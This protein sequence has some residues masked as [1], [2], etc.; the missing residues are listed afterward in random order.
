MKFSILLCAAATSLV[1]AADDRDL[2]GDV[3]ASVPPIVSK[4]QSTWSPPAALVKPL[5]EVWAHETATYGGGGILVFKNYGYDIINAAK[6]YFTTST[7]HKLY[8][9]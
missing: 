7:I 8:S 2:S 4:R 5:E 3:W 9:Y 6:G 1:L